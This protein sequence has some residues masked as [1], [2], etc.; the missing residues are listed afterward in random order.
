MNIRKFSL[1]FQLNILALFI[2]GRCNSLFFR[3]KQ[4]NY[5]WFLKMFLRIFLIIFAILLILGLGLLGYFLLNKYGVDFNKYIYIFIVILSC[6][7]LIFIAILILTLTGKKPSPVFIQK[8]KI[9]PY[10]EESKR[11][12]KSERGFIYPGSVRC[13]NPTSGRVQDPIIIQ[14]GPNAGRT[15][16]LDS[17]PASGWVPRPVFRGSGSR[18]APVKTPPKFSFGA[19]SYSMSCP[20]SNPSLFQSEGTSKKIID[21]TF[22]QGDLRISRNKI[23]ISGKENQCFYY[24]L[25]Q[26]LYRSQDD[27]YRDNVRAGILK[28]DY[29][30]GRYPVGM[31]GDAAALGEKASAFVGKDII[32]LSLNFDPK[33]G[34]YGFFSFYSSTNTMKNREMLKLNFSPTES[35]SEQRFFYDKLVDSNTYKLLLSNRHFE[36]FDVERI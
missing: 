10:R 29:D 9:V 13:P 25:S 16:N 24:A 27:I 6:L 17:L 20:P 21:L 26:L 18:P 12:L 34:M 15:L 7:A 35:V 3:F 5:S 31:M 36:L 28:T 4:I 8:G 23:S 30:K 19:D 11:L 22:P 33:K 1:I 32:V 14:T 2:F